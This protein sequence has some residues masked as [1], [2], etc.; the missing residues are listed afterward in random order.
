MSAKKW[1][2]KTHCVI[3]GRRL[4]RRKWRKLGMGL[5][6]REKLLKGYAGIQLKAFEE[7]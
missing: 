1:G 3:C 5:R 7:I 2:G 4:T 6:C